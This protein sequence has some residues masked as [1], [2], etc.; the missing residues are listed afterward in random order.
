MSKNQKLGYCVLG[1]AFALFNVI[2][3][4]IPTVKTAGFWIAYVFTIVAFAL[5]IAIW[6]TAFGK[7]KT[8][9][10]KFLGF[11][12]I[13]VGIVYLIVQLIAFAVFMVFTA[14]PTW[15]SL[16][17]CAVIAGVSGICLITTEI[18]RDEVARVESKVQK[19]VSSI[20][21]LYRKAFF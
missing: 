13:Y 20:T 21:S 8:L 5:Q 19:K 4:A 12:I 11:P 17:I 18:G 9:K 16:V 3:F 10:S 6:K 14:L 1:I 7:S 15:I 2:A